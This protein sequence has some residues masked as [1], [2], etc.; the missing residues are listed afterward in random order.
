MPPDLAVEVFSPGNRPGEMHKKVSEYL[1]VGTLSVWVVYPETPERGHYRSDD[2]HLSFFARTPSSKTSP[3]FPD[4]V[5]R[6]PTSSFEAV[7]EPHFPSMNPS[8]LRRYR[9][10]SRAGPG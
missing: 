7:A 5:V 10:T 6:C 2:D 4:F 9:S 3:S 8:V 1:E